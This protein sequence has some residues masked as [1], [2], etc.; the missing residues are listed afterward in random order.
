MKKFFTQT[1]QGLL[2]AL[3]AISVVAVGVT[4]VMSLAGN[5]LTATNIS[6][7]ELL[8]INLAREGVELITNI[9]DS[10]YLDDTATWDTGLNSGGT[11]D[12]GIIEYN[13]GTQ[14]WSIDFLSAN[15]TFA[16]N[17]T[18][19]YWD[20]NN[21]LYVQGAVEG[22]GWTATPYKRRVE[23]N[24]IC[25][26]DPTDFEEG[27]TCVGTTIGYRIL[28]EVQWTQRDNTRTVSVEKRLFNWR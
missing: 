18:T 3:I 10:N 16:N 6:S 26:E 28:S 27:A 8:A 19:M 14:T 9:R 25:S 21:L 13:T 7:Q 17:E 23:V 2:E 12:D 5:T 1:G 20:T 15:T 11:N 22:P 24:R 4:G